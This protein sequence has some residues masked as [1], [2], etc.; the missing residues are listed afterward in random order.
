MTVDC[1][2]LTFLAKSLLPPPEKYHGL[3]DVETRY[4]KRHLDIIGNVQSRNVLLARFKLISAIR[5]FLE[6]RGFLEVETPMLQ[7]IYGGASARPF[8]THHNSLDMDLYLRIA[9]ELYLKRLLVGGLS[10]KLFELNRNF[11]NEGLS[12]RHNPEFTMLE[13]YQAYTDRDGMMELV[14][15][16]IRHAT[17]TVGASGLVNDDAPMID[18]EAPFRILSMIDSAS[19]A[20]GADFRAAPVDKLHQAL[21]ACLGQPVDPAL[22]WGQ[23][24]EMAFEEFVGP[25][26]SQPTHVIDFPASISPLAKPSPVDPRI[27]DRFET[28]AGGMEIANAF[29]EMNDPLLQ[30]QVLER[31]AGQG[32]R[33]EIAPQVDEAF[34]EALEAGMPPAGGLGMGIDRLTMLA[35]GVRP[36]REVIAFPLLRSGGH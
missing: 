1:H 4:R 5:R 3:S 23:L 17:R 27:A 13:V 30:R 11:R 34:L 28:F 24:V 31:Q 20:V 15:A 36:I 7:P 32:R 22:E 18:F 16:M 26:L 8:M 10:D 2:A 29:S 25:H 9:P 19:E 35:V 12:T 33:G 21:S 14:E 6:D